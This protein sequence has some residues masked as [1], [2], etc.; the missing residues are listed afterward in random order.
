MHSNIYEPENL[1]INCL[2][3]VNCIDMIMYCT[4]ILRNID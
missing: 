4:I 3:H 1:F 2:D